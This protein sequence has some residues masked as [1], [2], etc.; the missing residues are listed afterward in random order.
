MLVR[1]SAKMW[2]TAAGFVKYFVPV[3][4]DN[5]RK[6]ED[7]E[8]KRV[9]RGGIY[10]AEQGEAKVKKVKLA[11]AEAAASI[12]HNVVMCPL[13]MERDSQ[14]VGLLLQPMVAAVE[15]QSVAA[16]APL[17][18]LMGSSAECDRALEILVSKEPVE[19]KPVLKGLQKSHITWEQRAVGAFL[20]LH[21]E[22]CGKGCFMSRATKLAAAL[23][24]AT[25]TSTRW[26]SLHHKDSKD[27][28][29]K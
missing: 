7:N 12:M 15:V 9:V 29:K 10:D 27:N 8:R 26:F 4:K 28:I 13:E 17:V 24:V 11:A 14:I 16:D 23:G 21:P 2:V 19:M 1:K 3:D 6:L 22:I 20:F 5:A 18:P 25:V